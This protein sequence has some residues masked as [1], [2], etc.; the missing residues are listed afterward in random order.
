MDGWINGG[1]YCRRKKVMTH[2][3]TRRT[4]LEQRAIAGEKTLLALHV[5]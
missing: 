1:S 3:P 4:A 5:G 2:W